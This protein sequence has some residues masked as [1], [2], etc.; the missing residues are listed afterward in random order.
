MD[1][2]EKAS[3]TGDVI[4]FRTSTDVT[5]EVKTTK[6][7]DKVLATVNYNP[8]TGFVIKS[9]EGFPNIEL[10]I[11]HPDYHDLEQRAGTHNNIKN[12][13]ESYVNN[14]INFTTQIQ[15]Q[16][17]PSIGGKRRKTRRRRNKR[18]Y[19]RRR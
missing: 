14:M 17:P 3:L 5:L 12:Q 1:I 8:E 11:Y 2:F 7:P 9:P 18:K 4:I 10:N 16:L 6:N 15:K 19:S 13:I